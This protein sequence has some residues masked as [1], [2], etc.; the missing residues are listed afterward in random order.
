MTMPPP[1]ETVRRPSR[2]TLWTATLLSLAG[3]VLAIALAESEY[4]LV[5]VRFEPVARAFYRIAYAIVLP[6]RG[7]VF[8]F[9]PEMHHHWSVAHTLVVALGAPFFYWGVWR[10]WRRVRGRLAVQA[11]AGKSRTGI[12]E[13]D[14]RSFLIASAA[15]TASFATGGYGVLIE[16]GQLKVRQYEIPIAGL[17]GELDGLRIVH[18]ADTHYGPFTSLEYL[19]SVI[20]RA[21]SLD[22]DLVALTGDYVHRSPKAIEPGIGLFARLESRLGAVAVLGNHEYWEGAEA[23]CAA[24]RRIGIPVLGN[25][26]VFVTRDGITGGTP[27]GPALCVAGVGDLWEKDVQLDRALL[28]LDNGIPAILLSHNPDV[29]EEIALDMRVDLMLAGHTHGGQVRLPGLGALAHTSQ[30]GDKYL[31]GLCVG[32]SCPVIVSRGAG[33]A[34]VPI[35]L[36]V[37]P[38]IGLVLLKRA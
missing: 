3:I 13:L 27:A 7:L 28:G 30:Y 11:D 37:P 25:R 33:L 2:Q 16:P 15:G 31:G 6:F 24:F 1:T 32:P 17:P 8:P 35:R 18:I 4:L 10:L 19:D 22:A 29:A 34:G 9:L 21:N 26:R 23:C 20:D 36:G 5:P 12:F 38:E 14:R